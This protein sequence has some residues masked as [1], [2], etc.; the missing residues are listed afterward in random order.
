MFRP[1]NVVFYI[2][3]TRHRAGPRWANSSPSL[4][5]ALRQVSMS[6][7][8][9]GHRGLAR[10][11]SCCGGVVVG[12]RPECNEIYTNTISPR[13]AD[14]REGPSRVYKYKQNPKIKIKKSVRD[15]FKSVNT[16]YSSILTKYEAVL[17]IL[18]PFRP[19]FHK[20]MFFKKTPLMLT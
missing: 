14:T 11:K 6:V 4:L 8:T 12:F 13:I 18:D 19:L 7:G 1:K 5:S 15:H 3:D 17:S 2:L 16:V 9:M 10:F 20:T